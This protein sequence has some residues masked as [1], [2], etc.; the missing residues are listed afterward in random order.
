[1]KTIDPAKLKQWAT[2]ATQLLSRGF[3]LAEAVLTL[4]DAYKH[5]QE[6][7]KKLQQQIDKQRRTNNFLYVELAKAKGGKDGK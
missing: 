3:L 5:M 2:Q 6:E 1:M 7:V 4:I